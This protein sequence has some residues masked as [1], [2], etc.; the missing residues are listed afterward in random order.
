[1]KRA[2]LKVLAGGIIL[3]T[4]A[5]LLG[6]AGLKEGWVYFLHVDQYV[7][8]VSHQ[9]QRVRLHGY[10]GAG[11][12]EVSKSGLVAKFNLEGETA[13]LRVEYSGVIPDMFRAGHEV[14]VE[15]RRNEEGVFIADTLM[16]KCGSRYESDGSEQPA[17]HPPV[18]SYSESTR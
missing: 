12:L 9:N 13:S 15:G 14:V 4:A 17:S 8:S 11:D 10:V 2:H 18:A 3:A 16:T 1:M 7:E 6:V 5:T